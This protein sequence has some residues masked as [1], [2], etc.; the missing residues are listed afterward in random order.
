MQGSRT[1][2]FA[3]SLDTIGA[4]LADG[5]STENMVDILG[6]LGISGIDAHYL[7]NMVL[8]SEYLPKS[9]E[10]PFSREQRYLHFLW[11]AFDRTPY[12]LAANLA[13]P[14]RR[15]IAR[16]LFSGCGKNFCAE[17][18][19]RFNFGQNIDAGDNIFINAGTFIDSKGGLTIGDAV[20]IGEF[21]RIFTHTHSESDHAERTYAPVLISDYAKVYAG[22]M[23]FPGVTIGEQAIVAGG[24]VVTKDVPPNAVVAGVPARVI[25]ERKTGGRT[26]E[27]LDHV[28]LFEGA[29]QDEK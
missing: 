17:A 25:R 26:R 20:G 28:W 10:M 19:I 13:I 4:L 29:F 9:A 18:N 15:M 7:E 6:I 5:P 12:S 24:A 27:E 21:V 8:Y 11:D 23:L 3:R 22:A 2:S 16:K 1:D 14:I